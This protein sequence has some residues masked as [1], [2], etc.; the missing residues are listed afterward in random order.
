VPP[1][2]AGAPIAPHAASVATY[3]RS[4]AELRTPELADLREAAP[5]DGAGTSRAESAICN[6]SS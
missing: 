1:V 4:H 2:G 6:C 3:M 5:K